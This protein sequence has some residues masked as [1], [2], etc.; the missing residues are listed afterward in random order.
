MPVTLVAQSRESNQFSDLHHNMARTRR[1][2]HA[3]QDF[4]AVYAPKVELP[5]WPTWI[6]RLP[7]IPRL[8][9]IDHWT[10]D[11]WAGVASLQVYSGPDWPPFVICPQGPLNPAGWKSAG[12]GA[13]PRWSNLAYEALNAIFFKTP[14]A[15]LSCLQHKISKKSDPRKIYDKRIDIK[16]PANW[17][18]PHHG[19]LESGK[20]KGVRALGKIRPAQ[21]GAGFINVEVVLRESLVAQLTRPLGRMQIP[22]VRGGAGP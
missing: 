22:P 20:Q 8:A 18:P 15:F 16:Y 6:Q 1:T 21:L 4:T 12:V 9:L 14:L 10:L 11:H 3:I 19:K 7:L 17:L 2:H 13:T 5:S